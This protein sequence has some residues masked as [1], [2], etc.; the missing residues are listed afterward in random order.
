MCRTRCESP[1]SRFLG[2]D[3]E[4]YHRDRGNP[5]RK[6]DGGSATSGKGRKSATLLAEPVTD[7]AAKIM[8]EGPC[9]AAAM[10]R[11]PRR[12]EGG[13]P[14]RRVNKI[15]DRGSAGAAKVIN[16]THK[17]CRVFARLKRVRISTVETTDSVAGDVRGAACRPREMEKGK[18]TDDEWHGQRRPR[19][20]RVARQTP[21][22]CKNPCVGC[23]RRGSRGLEGSH[24]TRRRHGE[25]TS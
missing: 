19:K 6:A 12:P 8:R 5:L 13:L 16:N 14:S 4:K 17:R 7:Q 20:I 10:F 22:P 18:A 24:D 25:S 2:V 15:D 1:S 23:G 9:K 21:V 11:R 3:T